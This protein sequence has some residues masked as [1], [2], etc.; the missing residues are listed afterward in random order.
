MSGSIP[1]CVLSYLRSVGGIERCENHTFFWC[2]VVGRRD[3]YRSHYSVPG[4]V[5]SGH[6]VQALPVLWTAW[7][8]DCQPATLASVPEF[9]LTFKEGKLSPLI[10]MLR[11]ESDLSGRAT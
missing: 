7:K 9:S 5:G 1:S 2:G 10:K 11:F 6:G 8:S 3:N 4:R